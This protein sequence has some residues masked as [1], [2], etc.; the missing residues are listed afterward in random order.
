M[1]ALYTAATGMS[2]RQTQLENIANNLA[3]STTTGFKKTRETFADLIYQQIGGTPNGE[4]MQLGSGTRVTSLSRDFRNGSTQIT[5][6]PTDIMI[7]GDGFFSATTPS[8]ETLYTRDGH[9]R[10]DL[11]GNLTTEE[12]Y[13]VQPGFQIPAGGTLMVGSD[14]TVSALIKNENGSETV[15]LGQFELTR[16][17]NPAALMAAGGNF[18]RATT[19]AGDPQ[20]S[21]PQTEGTGTLVQ[22]ALEG[23]NVD[24]AEELITM[25]SA[26]RSYELNSKVIQ[27]A[28]E[29]MQIAANLKR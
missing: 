23:S 14:G 17:P 19:A 27:T 10:I 21:I 5:S 2:S 12:G 18:Y 8:G 16:F 25:I 28:D 22:Y 26:Q 1:R 6:N 4:L 13:L 3:N 9:F 11:E 24:V 15:S 20:S 29:M 7:D